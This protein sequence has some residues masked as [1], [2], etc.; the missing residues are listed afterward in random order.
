VKPTVADAMEVLGCLQQL[1]AAIRLLADLANGKQIKRSLRLSPQRTVI[2]DGVSTTHSMGPLIRH[3]RVR[4]YTEKSWVSS[5]WEAMLPGIH[6]FKSQEELVERAIRLVSGLTL[7]GLAEAWW[8]LLPWS[9][10][11]DWIA[12]VQELLGFYLTNPLMLKPVSLCWMRTSVVDVYWHCTEKPDW[13]T[14][15]AQSFH[16][17]VTKER[18]PCLTDAFEPH[19]FSAL[20]GFSPRQ[21]SIL[22]GLAAQRWK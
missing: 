11:V 22:G 21:W 15:H 4:V 9:W 5:R 14:L 6:S 7:S 2:E 20:P 8:E 12:R 3:N 19:P 16:Q 1:L 17:E 10:L 18:I 13:V